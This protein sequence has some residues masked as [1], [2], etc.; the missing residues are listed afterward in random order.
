MKDVLEKLARFR[1]RGD[2]VDGEAFIEGLLPDVKRAPLVA[3]HCARFR[4]LQGYLTD[5]AALLKGADLTE[6]ASSLARLIDLERLAIGALRSGEFTQSLQRAKAFLFE[7]KALR[8]N[9]PDWA[10]CV[11]VAARIVKMAYVYYEVGATEA[12]A[13]RDQMFQAA[14]ALEAGGWIEE[15][16]NARYNHADWPRDAPE[17]RARALEALAQHALA[18]RRPNQAASA[19]VGAATINVQSSASSERI[20]S[21]LHAANDAFALS[22]NAVGA[23]DIELVNLLRAK[24]DGKDNKAQFEALKERLL[25]A[26]R[27]RD[28]LSVLIE[29]SQQAHERGDIARARALRLEMME[30]AETTGMGL[31]RMPSEVALADF[32][33]RSRKLADAMDLCLAAAEQQGPRVYQ[34]QA[35][36]I[37][38]APISFPATPKRR[39][40]TANTL[41]TFTTRLRPRIWRRSR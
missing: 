32:L 40:R 31:S 2:F 25:K 36:Q 3:L 21:L 5:A 22:G 26:G 33:I 24:R 11:A 29:L 39:S 20:S 15:A 6:V 9:D 38:R 14:E 41:W 8:A 13:V 34:A 35:R 27:P 17:L 4:A 7:A 12:D 18:H 30:L 37:F 28:A 1:E 19:F 16:L 23:L 10:E